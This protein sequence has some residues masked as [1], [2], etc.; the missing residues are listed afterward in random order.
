MT[1][2]LK[3]AIKQLNSFLK[4]AELYRKSDKRP[5]VLIKDEEALK[6]VLNN[7]KEANEKVSNNHKNL[8]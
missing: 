6:I 1:E 3:L 8:L 5:V 4:D 2:E 7:L